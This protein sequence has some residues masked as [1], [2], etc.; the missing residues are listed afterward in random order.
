M[1]EIIQDLGAVAVCEG[2][3]TVEQHSL[4]IDSGTDLVQG[5]FYAKPS[6]ELP[7]RSERAVPLPVPISAF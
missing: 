2:V 5:F 3:E 6:A 7:P 4:A 1:V